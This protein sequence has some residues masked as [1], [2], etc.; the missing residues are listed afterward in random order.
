MDPTYSGP[1]ADKADRETGRQGDRPPRSQDST[2][3]DPSERSRNSSGGRAT[4][5][6]TTTGLG[7]MYRSVRGNG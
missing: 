1:S 4:S 6:G 7:K 3:G 2:G 5:A